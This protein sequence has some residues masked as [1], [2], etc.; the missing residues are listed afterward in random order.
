[1]FLFYF[2]LV[3][4]SDTKQLNP[5]PFIELNLNWTTSALVATVQNVKSIDRPTGSTDWALWLLGRDANWDFISCF[6][7]FHIYWHS[8]RP[9]YVRFAFYFAYIMS[10]MLLL[11][12]LLSITWLCSICTLC[13]LCTLCGVSYCFNFLSDDVRWK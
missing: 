1:M 12:L 9:I 6:F 3:P 5:P 7:L 2:H 4:E 11:L 13:T 10:I 8:Q